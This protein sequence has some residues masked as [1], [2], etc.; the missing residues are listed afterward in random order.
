[1]NLKHFLSLLCISVLVLSCVQDEDE[2]TNQPANF[3]LD[4]E[5]RSTQMSVATDVSY[6]IVD[7]GF[8]EQVSGSRNFFTT[9][10]PDCAEITHTTNG[11]CSSGSITIDFGEGCTL[12]NGNFVEGEVVITY[13]RVDNNTTNF[14]YNYNNYA[15]NLI[16]V[17]GGGT[18]VR[19]YSNTNGNPQDYS[20]EN[21]AFTF[22]NSSVTGTRVAER[23]TVWVEGVESNT[24][25]DNVYE[26][27]GEWTTN[28]SNGFSRNGLVTETLIFR[29]NCPLIVE[30][31]V[32]ISQNGNNAT[33]DYGDGNCDSIAVLTIN[34][35]A[36]E[37]YVGN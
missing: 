2:T 28:L 8:T 35:I 6:S 22:P 12:N 37:I 29:L 14:T 31:V 21:I 18:G 27:E 36:Y 30:G 5:Q 13:E 3:S 9:F 16:G 24:W 19:T 26:M 11:N 32:Q 1:M 20:T 10:F 33:L 34:G 7:N 15:V 23:T 25:T 17:S 4:N